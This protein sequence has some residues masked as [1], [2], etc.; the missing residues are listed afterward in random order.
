M[1]LA[2]RL[3][4]KFPALALRD[5]ASQVGLVR[6]GHEYADLGNSRNRLGC[7]K[8]SRLLPTSSFS[9]AKQAGLFCMREDFKRVFFNSPLEAPR[10]DSKARSAPLLRLPP[11]IVGE[12]WQFLRRSSA[13]QEGKPACCRFAYRA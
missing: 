1:R 9:S 2:S 5:G 3:L 10:A 11:Q 8:R 13:P 6:L 4:K 12:A 7:V